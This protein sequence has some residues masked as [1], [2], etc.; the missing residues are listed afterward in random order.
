MCARETSRTGVTARKQEKQQ[1]KVYHLVQRA[2][3]HTIVLTLN[4]TRQYRL[5]S[6]Q[7]WT[8]EYATETLDLLQRKLLP[9]QIFCSADR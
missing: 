1:N 8:L 4:E 3:H 9:Q 5:E 7:S 2:N 6:A